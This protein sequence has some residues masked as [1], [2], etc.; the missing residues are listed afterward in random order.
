MIS[1]T[2]ADMLAETM[3][4]DAR[5]KADKNRSI[6]MANRPHKIQNRQRLVKLACR[7]GLTQTCKRVKAIM[8]RQHVDQKQA[9]LTK[10]VMS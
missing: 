8:S 10:E 7:F 3:I 1:P 5:R 6:E 9:K 2:L 4:K